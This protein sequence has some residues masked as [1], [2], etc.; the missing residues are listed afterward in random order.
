M[1]N[2]ESVRARIRNYNPNKDISDKDIIELLEE[3]IKQYRNRI[4]EQNRIIDELSRR[5]IQSEE[6][7]L[8]T[9]S[10]LIDE[11]IMEIIT[12]TLYANGK[13]IKMITEYKYKENKSE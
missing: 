5:E 3:E 10:E 11:D 4:R 2:Y 9:A 12:N 1:S 13:P 8:D 6:E 7:I